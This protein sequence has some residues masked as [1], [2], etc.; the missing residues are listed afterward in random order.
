MIQ[1]AGYI[2]SLA[3]QIFECPITN[4]MGGSENSIYS[5][6]KVKTHDAD[7]TGAEPASLRDVFVA[8]A[9]SMIW[10]EFPVQIIAYRNDDVAHKSWTRLEN[11]AFSLFGAT[12]RFDAI[13]KE[14]N[15]SVKELGYAVNAVSHAAG[16]FYYSL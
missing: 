11:A 16:E 5:F 15:P 1:H 13:T 3:R 2:N 7:I 6:P 8:E 9:N 10:Q 14:D 12:D 4:F